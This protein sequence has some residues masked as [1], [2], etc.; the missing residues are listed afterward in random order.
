M[1]RPGTTPSLYTSAS[2]VSMP[3]A[4][5][6]I[7]GKRHPASRLGLLDRDAIGHVVGGHE[8]QRAV[9]KTGPQ[10]LA[11]RLGTQRRRDD[12][13]GTAHRVGLVVAGLG[14]HEVVGTGLGADANTGGTGPTDL[15]ERRRRRQVH[16]V[17]RRIGGAREG[18]R[19]GGRDGLDV[20]WPGAGVEPWCGVAAREG[21]LDPGIEQDRILAVDL[22]HAA[23]LAHQLH[24]IEQRPVAQ[25]E[26]EHH[27]RLGRG[28]PGLDRGGQLGQRIV[29]LA[30]DR[31]GQPVIDGAVARRHGRPL[32]QAGQQRPLGGGRRA[33]SRDC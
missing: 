33:R 5:L 13:A 14:E 1:I 3:G 19:P 30:G 10:R 18:Q 26:V 8:V 21:P 11:I 22:E 2:S 25:P 32:P 20:G 17:D 27:E 12:R 28:D 29:R 23:A 7:D 15:L 4:P 31:Q 24:G 9:G 6:L 16:D